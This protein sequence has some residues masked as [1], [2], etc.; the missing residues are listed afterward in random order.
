M[1]SQ[2]EDGYQQIAHALQVQ[3]DFVADV[4][5]ELRTPLTTIRG[6]LALLER[7][8]A[9]PKAEQED[10]LRDLIGESE[11]LSRLVSDLLTLARADAGRKLELGPVDVGPLV[12][13]ARRQARVFAP[14]RQ[15]D[16]DD[17]ENLTGLTAYANEDVLKQVLLIL[18]DNAIKH[19]AGPIRVDL[20][21][22]DDHVI[23]RV[24]DSGPGH[25][26]R[27]PAPYLRPLLSR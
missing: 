27:P 6:N 22:A 16:H 17:D 5:H 8:P 24:Q 19:T 7:I 25:A 10:I 14:E 15:I 20:T 13:E 18:L 23:V 4:S 1:L 26:R 3:K 12:E 11:R 9:L 21:D 2:L